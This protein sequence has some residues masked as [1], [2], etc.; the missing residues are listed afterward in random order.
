MSRSARIEFHTAILKRSCI[1]GARF[2]GYRRISAEKLSKIDVF[3][4]LSLIIRESSE[5]TAVSIYELELAMYLVVQ[6]FRDIKLAIF[7]PLTAM[8]VP[9]H[10]VTKL[11][12]E[13][14]C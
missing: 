9:H 3:R 1:V 4:M 14:I 13:L 2:W 6:L 12:D 11:S 8:C 7:D 10:K 5:F